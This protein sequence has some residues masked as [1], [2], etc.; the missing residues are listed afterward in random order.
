L[1]NPGSSKYKTVYI[2]FH[3]NELSLLEDIKCFIEKETDI[4]GVIVVKKAKLENHHTAY[5]LKYDF[6]PKSHNNH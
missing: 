3:N 6:L 4:K 1:A 5:D 2:S